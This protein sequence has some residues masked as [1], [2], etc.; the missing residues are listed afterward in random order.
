MSS[1]SNAKIT[2]N[3][4]LLD[5]VASWKHEQLYSKTNQPV[6]ILV[7]LALLT[8]HN[9]V[10]L[11]HNSSLTVL[12]IVVLIPFIHHFHNITIEGSSSGKVS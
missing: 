2:Q 1:R 10:K 6:L 7:I 9:F 8:V 5:H 12:Y 11:H 4:D 3:V